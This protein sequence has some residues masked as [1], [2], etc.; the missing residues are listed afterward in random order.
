MK[1]NERV[2][3]N[4][5]ADYFN[6]LKSKNLRTSVKVQHLSVQK[7]WPI[8]MG[9]ANRRADVVIGDI[10]RKLYYAI[11]ECK[12]N[13]TVGHGPDQLKSYLCATDTP[14][15]IFA[16][17]TSPRFWT[18]YKN[19]RRGQFEE[20]TQSDFEQYLFEEQRI[21]SKIERLKKE[22]CQMQDKES[23]LEDKIRSKERKSDEVGQK[24]SQL[25][26]QK[27]RIESLIKNSRQQFKQDTQTRNSTSRQLQK[28]INQ[29]IGQKMDLELK[30]KRLRQ[31]IDILEGLKLDATRQELQEQVA[32]LVTQRIE[33]E[34]VLGTWVFKVLRWFKNLFRNNTHSEEKPHRKSWHDGDVHKAL[35]ISSLH[36]ITGCKGIVSANG[37]KL[38]FKIPAGVKNGQNLRLRGQGNSIVGDETGDLYVKISV[39]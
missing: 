28:R 11:A 26:Q 10:G 39:A 5:V 29:L 30:I 2:V 12:K 9:S 22:V 32:E 35:T 14:F 15:G 3:Q 24:I 34:K 36:A 25:Q 33:L 6:N 19:M 18:F 21:Q 20:I 13:G 31:D 4:L 16:N 27:F 38:N 1:S 37:K 23:E 17:N 7:E 8:Q